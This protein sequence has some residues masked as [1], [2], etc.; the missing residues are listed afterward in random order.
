M[1]RKAAD[2]KRTEICQTTADAHAIV[3]KRKQRMLFIC[4]AEDYAVQI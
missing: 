1:L 4:Y 3:K 2:I